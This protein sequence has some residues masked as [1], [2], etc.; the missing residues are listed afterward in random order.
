[1]YCPK[2]GA[3][4]ETEQKYC[5]L[6]GQPLAV[7]QLALEGRV[8]EAVAKYQKGGYSLS[9]S[10]I[11]LGLC[12]FGALINLLLIPSPWNVYAVVAN[13]IVGLVIALPMIISG[14]VRISRAN[15]L[16]S[17]E[18]QAHRVL[19]AESH[20]TETLLPPATVTD[21]LLSRVPIPGSVTEQTTRNLESPERKH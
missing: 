8:D 10:T 15:R 18:D 2:C 20:Q 11:A 19:K 13:S 5:R 1:M 16:L 6:C 21:P 7:L 17:S 3:Q 9:G 12:L 14:H 4:N